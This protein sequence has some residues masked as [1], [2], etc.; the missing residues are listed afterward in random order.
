M[1][2]SSGQRLLSLGRLKVILAAIK[3]L[4]AA[5]ANVNARK[6]FYAPMPAYTVQL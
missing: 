6:F 3:I 1:Q 5:G 4:I 2:V